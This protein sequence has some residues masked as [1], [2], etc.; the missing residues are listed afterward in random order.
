MKKILVLVLLSHITRALQSNN[1]RKID[2]IEE[3]LKQSKMNSFQCGLWPINYSSLH[4]KNLYSDDAKK[5]VFMP[6]FSGMKYLNYSSFLTKLLNLKVVQVCLIESLVSQPFFYL[7][8]SLIEFSKWVDV[9]TYQFSK[10]LLFHQTLIGREVKILIG[11]LNH[12]V[13]VQK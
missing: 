10:Q 5:I 7:P 12:C 3:I 1:E 6:N 8:S 4:A 9:K 11:F 13:Q 2:E